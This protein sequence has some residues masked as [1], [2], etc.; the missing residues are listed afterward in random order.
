M[1]ALPE[2]IIK[3]VPSGLDAVRDFTD[4]ASNFGLQISGMAIADGEIHR[5]PDADARG[6]RNMSGW[7]VLSDLDGLLYGSFGSWKAGRGQQPWCNRDSGSLTIV[8]RH[9]IQVARD[10]Q[11][12]AIEERRREAAAQASDDV[13][14]AE[15]AVDAHPYLLSKGVRSHGLLMQGKAL[16]VPMM[17][18]SG[19]VISHQTIGEDGSKRFLAGGKKRGAFFMIGQ[20]KNVIYVAEG[21]ATAASVFEATGQCSVVAFDAGNLVPVVEGLRGAW[22]ACEIV[23]AADNDESGAGLDGARKAKPDYIVMPDRVGFDWNDVWVADGKDAVLAGVQSRIVRVMASGFSASEMRSVEPRKW[24]YGKHLIR[25]YVSAT[26]S[27]GGVGKTT[28]SASIS[29]G[30]AMRGKKT[31]VIDFDVGLRNLDLVMG[32]ERRVI[33][34][35][36][37]VI[38]KEA[39][40]SQALIKDKRFNN[41]YILPA[42]QTKNKDALT[43]EGVGKVIEELKKDFDYIVCDSPAGIEQGAEMAMY[44]A[45]KALVVAAAI[46]ASALAFVKYKFVEPSAISSVLSFVAICVAMYAL[47]DC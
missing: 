47:T 36:I 9:A 14:A 7:Y 46:L 32:C 34:D 40:L 33:Y 39:N 18:A 43:K 35:L 28:T 19:Q 22:P 38:Y 42:S 25:G 30:L 29:T 17:D 41:L 8:E 6:R 37:N 11:Q 13:A 21:Y 15:M 44:F 2:I 3:P 31:C 24:L 16:L 5:V 23:V 10:A 12:Q 1:V 20:P 45:D 26:V 4:A 27:P